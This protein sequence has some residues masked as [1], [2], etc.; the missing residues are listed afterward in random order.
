MNHPLSLSNQLITLSALKKW[1]ATAYKLGLQ[2]VEV[3]ATGTLLI[4]EATCALCCG[5]ELQLWTHWVFSLHWLCSATEK[6]S[7]WKH[8]AEQLLWNQVVFPLNTNNYSTS[9]I[10]LGKRTYYSQAHLQRWQVAHYIIPSEND[11][12]QLK[13]RNTNPFFF[14]PVCCTAAPEPHSNDSNSCHLP[15]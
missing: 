11:S 7:E 6:R 13:K 15:T 10:P 1:P 8:S 3:M 5:T 12:F 14:V 2:L 9:F 4:G